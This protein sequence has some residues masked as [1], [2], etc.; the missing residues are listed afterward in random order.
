[1]I[2]IKFDSRK[3][4]KVLKS[5]CEG[6]IKELS[7]KEMEKIVNSILRSKEFCHNFLRNCLFY[8]CPSIMR[9]M[10]FKPIKGSK[11][12]L[13]FM[14]YRKLWREQIEKAFRYEPLALSAKRRL[15]ARAVPKD[16]GEK[17]KEGK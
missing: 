1:M 17:P 16:Y 13:E 4:E 6:V 14:R 7:Q 12:E 5:C 11:K 15:P 2:E 9:R 3:I 8:H 10:K